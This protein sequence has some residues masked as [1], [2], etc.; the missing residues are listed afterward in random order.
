MSH[1]TEFSLLLAY[2]KRR[3][4]G[5]EEARSEEFWDHG[6]FAGVVVNFPL[7]GVPSF[8]QVAGFYSR[9]NIEVE[10]SRLRPERK[11]MYRRF[12]SAAYLAYRAAQENQPT[13]GSVWHLQDCVGYITKA[14][15][16]MEKSKEY[17]DGNPVQ[18]SEVY[19]TESA[20]HDTPLPRSPAEFWLLF[21]LESL[22]PV[23][24][25]S[26]C[27]LRAAFPDCKDTWNEWEASLRREE[28]IQ[29]FILDSRTSSWRKIPLHAPR[30]VDVLGPPTLKAL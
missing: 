30:R 26:V 1:L 22:L 7:C 18:W 10:R 20:P 28:W 16:L 24:G 19:R 29:Q 2:V 13:K 4:G 5:E 15:R 11:T 21:K 8:D 3:L 6:R 17:D 14:L 27:I 12:T 9:L 23:L 25:L